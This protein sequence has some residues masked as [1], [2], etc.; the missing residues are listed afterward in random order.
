MRTSSM[1]T[2]ADT[3]M[4]T[5]QTVI[6][7]ALSSSRAAE[8]EPVEVQRAI[9]AAQGMIE[10]YLD[11]PLMAQVHTERLSRYDWTEERRTDG[12]TWLAW[13]GVQPIIEVQ[14]PSEVSALGTDRFE[15]DRPQPGPVDYIAGWRREDQNKSDFDASP[16]E[17]PPELPGDIRRVGVEVTLYLLNEAEHSAGM[18]STEQAVGGGSTVTISGMDT[19]FIRRK[20]S[21]LDPYK[22]AL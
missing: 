7:A 4:L 1:R 20:L 17:D 2:M 21:M 3:A 18:G 19:G 5:A 15:R 11:R 14:S 9:G 13:A 8:E 22:R 10:S 16:S 12:T 6:G